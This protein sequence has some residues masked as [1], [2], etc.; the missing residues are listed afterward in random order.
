MGW[1][2]TGIKIAKFTE[3]TEKFQ[4]YFLW[5]EYPRKWYIFTYCFL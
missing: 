2:L 5:T 4:T 3:L 1:Q